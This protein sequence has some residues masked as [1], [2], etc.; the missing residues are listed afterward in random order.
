MARK[1]RE[2]ADTDAIVRLDVGGGGR[3]GHGDAVGELVDSHAP[4]P[5][6]M[7]RVA[8]QRQP[9]AQSADQKEWRKKYVEY[10]EVLCKPEVAGDPVKA[11]M[12]VFGLDEV[13][14][15]DRQIELHDKMT[16]STKG[17]SVTELMKR[18]DITPEA[19][20]MMLSRHMRSQDPRISIV[21]IKEANDMDNQLAAAGAASFEDWAALIL[22]M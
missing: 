8:E 5:G 19:R 6:A 13:T 10:L 7:K 11:I 2:A 22:G 21:A 15:R 9:R 16:A 14:A 20:I 17:L 4:M 1:K 12:E 3:R 18:Y